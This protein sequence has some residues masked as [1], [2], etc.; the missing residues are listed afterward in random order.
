MMI[1]DESGSGEGQAMMVGEG[2][3]PEEQDWREKGYVTSVKY[4]DHCGSCWA[5]S[6]AGALEGQYFNKTGKQL[7]IIC[8]KLIR[9][10]D[11]VCFYIY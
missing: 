2:E 10:Q 5:F 1:P 9:K 3:V 11:L 6:A 7:F 8:L 4:Q